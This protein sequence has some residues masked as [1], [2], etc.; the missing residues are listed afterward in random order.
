LSP[1][2]NFLEDIG[3]LGGPYEG[4]WLGIVELQVGFDCG[5]EFGDA[6]EDAAA[7]GVA[8]DQTEESFDQIDPGSR[9][10]GEV[11]VEAGVALE[12]SIDLGVLVGC[13][14]VDVAN[15]VVVP[16]RL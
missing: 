5:L 6:A 4:L 9:C 11:E 2:G 10:R 3:G 8:G 15:R 16:C 7:D 1:S 12:P 14:V 13:V